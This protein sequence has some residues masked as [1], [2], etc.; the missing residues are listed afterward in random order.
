MEGGWWRMK[1]WRKIKERWYE[2]RCLDIWC[3]EHPSQSKEKGLG[4]MSWN[5]V[6][7]WEYL[8]WLRERY[9]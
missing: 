7:M 5:K 9:N 8:I 3:D 1:V 4:Q 6:G 2:I